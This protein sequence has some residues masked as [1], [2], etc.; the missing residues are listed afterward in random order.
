MAFILN[1]EYKFLNS[2]LIISKLNTYN[3]QLQNY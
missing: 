3:L 2:L 1:I